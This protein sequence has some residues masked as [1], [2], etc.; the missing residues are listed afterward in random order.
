MKS[1]RQVTRCPGKHQDSYDQSMMKSRYWELILRFTTGFVSLT[2]WTSSSNSFSTRDQEYYIIPSIL[3]YLEMLFC[4]LY[5]WME[6][7]LNI[8]ILAY[9]FFPSELWIYSS[10]VYWNNIL[11]PK[12]LLHCS[13]YDDL[14]FYLDA[15]RILSLALYFSN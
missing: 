15:W 10:I 1:H 12:M 7:W 5:S 11:L 9:I 8:I 4:G 13:L 6:S 14:R 3:S 2:S